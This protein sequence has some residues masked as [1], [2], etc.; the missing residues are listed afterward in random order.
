MLKEIK[1]LT[2]LVKENCENCNFHY[3][4]T[5]KAAISPHDN[6]KNQYKPY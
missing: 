5:Q 3:L 4:C 1:I 2:F 6:Q